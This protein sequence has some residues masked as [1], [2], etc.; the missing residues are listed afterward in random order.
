MDGVITPGPSPAPGPSGPDVDELRSS[1]DDLLT[2]SAGARGGDDGG[3]DGRG[4]GVSV[5]VRD[6]QVEAL[7]AA[8]ELLATALAALDATR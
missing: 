8:H 1:F 4:T 2:D 7:D 5:S 6:H 3:D